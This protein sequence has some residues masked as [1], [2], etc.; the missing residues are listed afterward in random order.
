MILRTLILIL[1]VL[2]FL[3]S[4]A[5]G[6]VVTLKV[7]ESGDSTAHYEV[8]ASNIGETEDGTQTVYATAAHNISIGSE[9]SINVGGGDWRP[10]EIAGAKGDAAILVGPHPRRNRR[11]YPL[12]EPTRK[13]DRIHWFGPRTGRTLQAT[14][15][16]DSFALGSQGM[17]GDSGGPIW[18]ERAEL[19]G[20]FKGAIRREDAAASR[21]PYPGP[22]VMY[23]P[24][25]VFFTLC[26]ESLGYVPG[27]TRMAAAPKA[28]PAIRVLYF[29]SAFCGPCKITT[30]RVKAMIE[31]GWKLT[32]YTAESDPKRFDEWGVSVVPSF[33]AVKGGKE[34]RRR[35]GV[36]SYDEIAAL[37]AETRDTVA[38]DCARPR[39]V[40]DRPISP[41]P[42]PQLSR[43]DCN[44]KWVSLDKRV[45]QLDRIVENNYVRIE[46][47]IERIQHNSD[48]DCDV[49]SIEREIA[50]LKQRLSDLKAGQPTTPDIAAYLAEH[51]RDELRG[52]QGDRGPQGL[53]G[54]TGT[55]GPE[56]DSVTGPQGPPGDRGPQGPAGVVTVHVYR[57]GELSETFEGVRSGSRVEVEIED[58]E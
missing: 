39:T 56:G 48:C 33:V 43:C 12:G 44:E 42:D 23:T 16:S 54:M 58:E 34:V 22:N 40:P 26:R 14:A 11:V 8:P 55:R 15:E 51:Y 38:A 3:A 57:D 41:R 30:P 20:V 7:A 27:R 17:Q 49:E 13:G 53:R 6:Q 52:P 5:S 9:C 21:M 24:S 46:E 47:R 2:L 35:T 4:Q 1:D 19:V 36:L 45:S 37:F 10:V 18:N 31:K 32:I 25:S 28:D 29:S 50:K